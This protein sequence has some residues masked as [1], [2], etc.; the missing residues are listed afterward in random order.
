MVH[1]IWAYNNHDF[2]AFLAAPTHITPNWGH[3][4]MMYCQLQPLKPLY[5]VTGGL[6]TQIFGF[7]KSSAI[8]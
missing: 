7:K 1:D 8:L 4:P 2:L 3:I 5:M 6:G